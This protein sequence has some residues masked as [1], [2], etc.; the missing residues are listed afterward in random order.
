MDAI[1]HTASF[2]SQTATVL[3]ML[4]SYL[5]VVGIHLI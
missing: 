3:D 4:D 1:T 5:T 2:L